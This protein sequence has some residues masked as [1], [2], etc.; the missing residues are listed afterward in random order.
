MPRVSEQVNRT[1]KPAVIISNACENLPLSVKGKLPNHQAIK[2]T[3]QR[4][5]VKLAHC[6]PKPENITDLVIPTTYSKYENK[7][8]FL[9]ILGKIM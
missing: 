6:S 8:F 1:L 2:K 3:I 4:K 5:F 9:E 7:R